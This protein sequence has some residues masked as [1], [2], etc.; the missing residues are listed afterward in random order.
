MAAKRPGIALQQ[1]SHLFELD[2]PCACD[3]A[4]DAPASHKAITSGAQVVSCQNDSKPSL[5]MTVITLVPSF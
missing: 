5:L 2:L 3:G 4:G 1:G